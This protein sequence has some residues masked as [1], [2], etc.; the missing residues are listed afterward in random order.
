MPM[1]SR[2]EEKRHGITVIGIRA[3]LW[4]AVGAVTLLSLLPWLSFYDFKVAADELLPPGSVR[5]THLSSPTEQ[6]EDLPPKTGDMM[7]TKIPCRKVL[8]DK[9][10]KKRKAEE[11]AATHVPAANIQAQRVVGDKYGKEGAPK[12]E[13]FV[14]GLRCNPL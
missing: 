6:L 13:R 12:K 10:K 7:T 8:D 1:G 3:F 2:H 9:E 5:V 14:L 11:K 4:G